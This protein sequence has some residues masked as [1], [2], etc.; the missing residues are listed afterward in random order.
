M[1]VISRQLLL[2]HF[3]HIVEVSATLELSISSVEPVKG[4]FV[5]LNFNG[6]RM[7]LSLAGR[8]SV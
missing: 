6:S 2:K 1:A 3:F 7:Q 8:V 5:L 4:D